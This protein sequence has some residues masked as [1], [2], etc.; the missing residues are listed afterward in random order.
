MEH[1]VRGP[2]GGEH[3]GRG[4]GTRVPPF[5]GEL[6]GQRRV[7]LHRFQVQVPGRHPARQ[8]LAKIRLRHQKPA[9]GRPE[10]PGD[11]Q[12]VGVVLTQLE[13]LYRQDLQEVG[14]TERLGLGV[15]LHLQGKP[16][17]AL[18]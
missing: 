5:Q 6:R 17:A 2:T 7:G 1:P 3:R 10:V 15:E 11:D 18:R 13:P 4:H 9:V 14:R 16:A 12:C 8:G